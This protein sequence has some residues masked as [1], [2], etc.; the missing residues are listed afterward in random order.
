MCVFHPCL[1][2]SYITQVGNSSVMTSRENDWTNLEGI[3]YKSSFNLKLVRTPTRTSEFYQNHVCKCISNLPY[4]I[5]WKK[6]LREKNSGVKFA[7]RRE[8]AWV[9]RQG[10]LFWERY[11]TAGVYSLWYNADNDRESTPYINKPWKISHGLNTSTFN[12]FMFTTILRA[13]LK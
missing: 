12:V 10:H 11:P 7:I 2:I 6:K 3:S 1:L 13:W 8:P 5:L 9:L 4:A